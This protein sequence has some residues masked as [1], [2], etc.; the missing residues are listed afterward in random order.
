MLYLINKSWITDLLSSWFFPAIGG[1]EQGWY[2]L[3]NIH[4]STLAKLK[5][6]QAKRLAGRRVIRDGS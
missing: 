2:R 1:D 3:K 4:A 5:E 6:I